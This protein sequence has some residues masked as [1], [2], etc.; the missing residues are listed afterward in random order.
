MENRQLGGLYSANRWDRLSTCR[1]MPYDPNMS[2]KPI[3][4]GPGAVSV[5]QL[6][7]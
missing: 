7:G 3:D 4:G 5:L 1:S 6:T 2:D